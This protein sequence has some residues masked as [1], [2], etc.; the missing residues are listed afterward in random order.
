MNVLND[1]VGPERKS[2][3][4]RRRLFVLAGLVAI[5]VAV[6]LVIVKPGSTGGAATAPKVDLPKDVVAAD[7]PEESLKD[8]EIAS[9]KASDLE[10]TPIT[11]RNTYAAGE[12]PLLSLSVQNISDATCAADLGTATMTFK[13]WSGTDEVWRSTDCQKDPKS[14]PVKLKKGEKLTTETLAWDRTRSSTETCDV[15][16]DEVYG[17]GST[18]RLEVSVAGVP[19]KGSAPFLLY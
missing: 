1:P 13:V 11:D 17:D 6:V 12:Q 10:V 4:L 15:P 2:V 18:Y 7:A 16:R 19:G 5:V 3:Y 8:G 14:Q 9:C